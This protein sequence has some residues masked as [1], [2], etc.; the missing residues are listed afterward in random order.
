MLQAC[1]QQTPPPA[2]ARNF[3]TFDLLVDPSQLP[4]VWKS[5]SGAEVSSCQAHHFDHCLRVSEI[6]YRAPGITI[7]QV[8]GQFASAAAAAQT[9]ADHFW[10][11]DSIGTLSFHW[12]AMSGFNYKSPM[13]NQFRVVCN[14]E[15]P[16]AACVVE[17][18]YEEYGSWLFYYGSNMHQATSDLELVAKG[19]DARMARYLGKP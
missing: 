12:V 3:T 1:L 8:V 2:P 7:D 14:T 6:T 9:Y 10:T 5:E 15:M 4:P 18:Q 17:A 13:A 19:V 11:Q 16:G